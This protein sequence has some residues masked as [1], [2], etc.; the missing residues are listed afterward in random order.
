MPTLTSQQ[1]NF[2]NNTTFRTSYGL[3]L[4]IPNPA[5]RASTCHG[6]TMKDW[7]SHSRSTQ[8]SNAKGI[9]DTLMIHQR[10]GF[11]CKPT[12]PRQGGSE[13]HSNGPVQISGYVYVTEKTNHNEQQAGARSSIFGSNTGKAYTQGDVVQISPASFTMDEA[14]ILQIYAESERKRSITGAASLAQIM[15]ILLANILPDLATASPNFDVNQSDLCSDIP[16]SVQIALPSA[17]KRKL[18]PCNAGLPAA[19]RS[20]YADILSGVHHAPRTTQA[21]P[22]KRRRSSASPDSRS[23]NSDT[24]NVRAGRA[25]SIG[26]LHLDQQLLRLPQGCCDALQERTADSSLP[27]EDGAR[28]A[29]RCLPPP[30]PPLR[31]AATRISVRNLTA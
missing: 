1:L 29:A 18:P 14:R 7:E 20:S 12:L 8:F 6:Q 28:S 31:E 13:S 23:R 30:V 16:G 27:A 22:K 21:L 10:S 11:D 25:V 5:C 17:S 26:K 24:T 19:P 15:Q 4:Q 3:E 9:S 2:R